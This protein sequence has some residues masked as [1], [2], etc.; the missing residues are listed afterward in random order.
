[1][2]EA[3]GKNEENN[4]K[5]VAIKIIKTKNRIIKSIDKTS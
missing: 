5:S 1:M 2:G 4:V 3:N